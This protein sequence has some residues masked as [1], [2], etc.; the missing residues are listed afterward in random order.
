MIITPGQLFPDPFPKGA[1]LLVNKPLA[2]TSF[3][4]VNKVRY[5]LSRR[6]GNKKLK[7]GHAGTLDPLAT[8]LLIICAGDFT[9]RIDEFQ[10]M[11]KAYEGTIVLGATTPSFDLEKAPDQFFPTEHITPALMEQARTQFIGDIE[12]IP[13]VFSAVKVDGRRL[14][15]NARTGEEVELP[16]RK[17]HIDTFELLGEL[18]QVV[19]SG[20]EAYV[21]SKKGAPIMLH[22]DYAKGVQI[23]FRVVCS[24]GTYIRALAKDFG[25]AVQS[26]AYLSRLVR[27]GTGGFDLKDAWELEDLIRW[28]GEPQ[29]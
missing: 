6:V 12:Q 19:S 13:P 23:D 4:V 11:V 10:A 15:K 17:V 27:T 29:L 14:Y 2:W 5:F 7:V 21:A 26:G 24:K 1:V 28:I 8:G 3:D 16:Q 25:E 22:P 9:K 18:R 20:K